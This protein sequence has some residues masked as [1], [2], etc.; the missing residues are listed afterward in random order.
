MTAALCNGRPST[1][2]QSPSRVLRLVADRDVGVQVGVAGAGVA[3]DE[4]RGHQAACLHLLDPLTAAAGEQHLLLQVL[5]R[6]GNGGLVRRLHL[7][8]HRPVAPPPTAPTPT[9]PA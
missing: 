2:S 4:L 7:P 3:M 5:Q 6:C 1:A 8:G 9:S